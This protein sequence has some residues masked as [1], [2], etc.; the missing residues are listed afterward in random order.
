MRTRRLLRVYLQRQLRHE[1]V[2]T[3]RD[4]TRI[5]AI[6]MVLSDPALLSCVD[7]E[8]D[9]IAGADVNL[10][11]PL[12]QIFWWFWANREQIMK[13]VLAIASFAGTL[14]E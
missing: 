1:E 4:P 11:A 5:R 14:D 6:Q 12:T 8:L 10:G 3:N 13:I 9:S 7:A 2:S